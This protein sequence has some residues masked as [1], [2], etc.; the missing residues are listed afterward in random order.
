MLAKVLNIF[1]MGEVRKSGFPSSS[2]WNKG[3]SMLIV[4]VRNQSHSSSSRQ[5]TVVAFVAEYIVL[6]VHFQKKREGHYIHL[7]VNLFS[8]VFLL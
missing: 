1:V 4:T 5:N 2:E 7:G 6:F 8:K 3:S